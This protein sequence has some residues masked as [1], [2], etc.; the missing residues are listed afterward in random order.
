MPCP[1]VISI[2]SVCVCVGVGVGVRLTPPGY[3]KPFK[4]NES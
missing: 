4:E 3:E 2:A 1:S